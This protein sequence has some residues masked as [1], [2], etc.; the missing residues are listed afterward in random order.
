MLFPGFVVAW[1]ALLVVS[2]SPHADRSYEVTHVLAETPAGGLAEDS[3]G[4]LYGVTFSGGAAGVGTIYRL[5][6]AGAVTVA[7]FT[8][9][10]G[11]SSD[12]GGLLR[13]SDGNFYGTTEGGSEAYPDGTIFRFTPDGTLSVWA[14]FNSADNGATPS[15][16]LI[17]GSDGNLYGTALFG[18]GGAPGVV[19]RVNKTGATGEIEAFAF[20]PV[21]ETAG[22]FGPAGESPATGVVEVDGSF[23]G[24]AMFGG[25]NGLGTIFHATPGNVSAVHT[26]DGSDGTTPTSPLLLG[27]GHVLYGTTLG[28]GVTNFGTLF[29]FGLDDNAFSNL[30]SFNGAN[31]DFP[32]QQGVIE[33]DG[34]LFGTTQMGGTAGRGV[35]Y[36]WS[37]STGLEVLHDM[38]AVTDGSPIATLMAASDGALYGVGSRNDGGGVIFRLVADTVPSSLAVNPAIGNVGGT[39]ELMAQLMAA[40]QPVENALVA[41]SLNGVSVGSA[42]TDANGIAALSG[43][44]LAGIAVGHYPGA[45]AAS[46]AGNDQLL[47][48]TATDDL[49]IIDS[50]PPVLHLPANIV[51]NATSA[52]GAAVTYAVTATDNSGGPVV[53]SCT[54]ASGSVFPNGVTTVNC[55]A[56]DASHNVANGSFTV[57]VVR[58]DLVAAYG[59]EEALAGEVSDGSL[60]GNDGHFDAVN[61][62]QRVERGRFGRAMRFDGMDDWIT[63]ADSDSLDLGQ[64][65]TLMAW[66]KP[67]DSTGWRTVVLK[68]QPEGLAYGLYANDATTPQCRPGGYV[69]VWG[70][71]RSAVANSC[72]APNEWVHI[73]TTVQSGTIRIYVNGTLERTSPSQ[74][75][76]AISEGALRIGGNSF[77]GE[78][79]KGTI[80]EIRVYNRSLAAAEITDDMM[81][82]VVAG[83]LAAPSPVNGL[84]AAYSFNDGTAADATGN[85]HQ[86]TISGAVGVS[87]KYGSALS[88][89]G[90]DDKVSIANAADL[91][92]K[93]GMTLEAWVRPDTLQSV[94]AIV[95][96]EA[97]SGLAYALY[98]NNSANRPSGVA[99]IAGAKRD[100]TSSSALTAAAWSHLAVTY[101]GSLLKLWVNG[102]LRGSR[103]ITGSILVSNGALMIGGSNVLGEHFDGVIDNVR[104]YNRALGAEEVQTNMVTPIE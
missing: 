59:F 90:V 80:D 70:F 55:T 101:N 32:Y 34:S 53:I 30:A 68:E 91:G 63:V 45:I 66:V 36:R 79:L 13:A 7:E 88:F 81:T 22:D 71:D 73:A 35:V 18:A 83:A 2:L 25:A 87:G 69:N 95:L 33:A 4:T 62:P 3:A 42:T 100:A 27:S 85:G 5:T 93:T 16:P 20:F 99:S 50:M 43:V 67:E 97:P 26:F 15:G 94:S 23:Y 37:A 10:M 44:S 38:D 89:D 24:S 12:G 41:F 84:V 54:P 104:L 46:F 31:G 74:G 75:N 57:T 47:P 102:V 86:G 60:H 8:A 96:K 14:A 1:L 40:G 11:F 29:Q 17:E 103:S 9:D 51:A 64:A 78:Y 49:T 98:A 72:A 39:T 48:S 28:D 21:P 92:F 82:P 52:Q 76:V 61:G 56:T 58:K 65:F 6:P 77:W 19:Y